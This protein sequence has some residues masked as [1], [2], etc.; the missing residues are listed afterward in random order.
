M[1]ELSDCWA[2]TAAAAA[3]EVSPVL[4]EVPVEVPVV[5]AAGTVALVPAC[6]IELYKPAAS[7]TWVS[8]LLVLPSVATMPDVVESALASAAKPGSPPA[9]TGEA[10]LVELVDPATGISK[11]AGVIVLSEETDIGA[12]KS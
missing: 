8:V 5:E 4:L 11:D 2:D 9:T 7:Y 10:V 1:D 3:D 6:A 12:P